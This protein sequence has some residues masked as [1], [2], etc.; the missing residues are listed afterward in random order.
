MASG[1]SATAAAQEIG[2]DRRTVARWWRRH[3]EEGNMKDRHAGGN[4]R[5]TT[6]DENR[7][8][9]EYAKRHKNVTAS[10]IKQALN[11]ECSVNTIRR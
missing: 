1:Y 4:N 3:M 10:Q 5:S 7:R 8:I 11:L 6:A 9:G 2:R